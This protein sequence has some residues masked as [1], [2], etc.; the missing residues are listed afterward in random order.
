MGLLFQGE[1]F[2]AVF[3]HNQEILSLISIIFQHGAWTLNLRESVNNR[4]EVLLYASSIWILDKITYE[5][6]W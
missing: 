6:F 2:V 3:Q 1:S 5:Q 4:N